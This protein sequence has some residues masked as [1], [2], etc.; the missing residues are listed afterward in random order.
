MGKQYERLSDFDIKF[1]KEQKLYFIASC[2]DQEVNLSP[3]GYE[4]IYLHDDKTVYMLDFPGSG[5]RTASD[6]HK[7]G[8]ITILFQAFEGKPR[9]VRLFCK[10]ECIQKDEQAFEVPY[11]H[12]DVQKDLIR[13]IF[14]FTIQ[15]VESSCGMSI[16][17]MNYEKERNELKDWALIMSEKGELKSYI[18]DHETPPVIKS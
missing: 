18:D 17:Y 3:K 4:S 12:F 8:K 13:Q 2:S 7:D 16:P 11:S 14:K 1:I 6:I 9:I 10:G 15:T 5:N